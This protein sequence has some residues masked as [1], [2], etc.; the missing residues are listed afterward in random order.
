MALR[1]KKNRSM[2]QEYRGRI[3][4]I[5]STNCWQNFKDNSVEK[6]SL[7]NKW[8]LKKFFDPYFTLNKKLTEIYQ[9]PKL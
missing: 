6:S 8:S 4:H 5:L 2:E 1:Y 3:T 9:K 7:F